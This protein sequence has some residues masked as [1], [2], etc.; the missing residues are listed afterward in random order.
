MSRST[1]TV[2]LSLLRILLAFS[3][4]RCDT[5]AAPGHP[6]CDLG[7][8]ASPPLG[9]P[10]LPLLIHQQRT[11]LKALS[12]CSLSLMWLLTHLPG[13]PAPR[14]PRWGRPAHVC[15]THSSDTECGH[16][17]RPGPGY[18]KVG[19]ETLPFLGSLAV[20]AWISSD[21]KSSGGQSAGC[22]AH[23]RRTAQ[24]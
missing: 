14:A 3:L 23:P 5:W 20:R 9:E 13:V 17:K 2:T 8:P 10:L 21:H 7:S 22:Q 1:C 12:T 16:H 6:P 4:P 19:V 24:L 18:G 11:S 15:V